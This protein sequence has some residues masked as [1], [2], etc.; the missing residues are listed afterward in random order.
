[1]SEKKEGNQ[2]YWINFGNETFGKVVFENYKYQCYETS[3]F[4]GDWR[5]VGQPFFIKEKAIEFLNSLT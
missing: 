4:G 3:L 2:I 1:M 5:K